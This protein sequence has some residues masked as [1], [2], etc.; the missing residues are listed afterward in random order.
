MSTNS[1]L[2]SLVYGAS[3]SDIDTVWSFGAVADN[4]NIT[5]NNSDCILDGTQ[6]NGSTYADTG[7]AGGFTTCALKTT[8]STLTS[9]NEMLFCSNI[10]SGTSYNGQAADFEVLVPTDQTLGAT[11]TYY[12]FASLG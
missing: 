11:E 2:P 3:G 7:P 8:N 12:L 1:S 6:I 10:T 9:K 5:F 4:G